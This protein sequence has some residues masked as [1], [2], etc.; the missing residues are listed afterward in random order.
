MSVQKESSCRQYVFQTRDRDGVG[1]MNIMDLVL[2]K[3]DMLKCV[4]D[5][6]II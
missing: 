6:K 3:T 1:V 2:V 4:H 5:V